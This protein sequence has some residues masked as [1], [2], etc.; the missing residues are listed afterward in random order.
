MIGV[1]VNKGV[2]FSF[3]KQNAVFLGP[4]TFMKVGDGE[5]E[6]RERIRRLE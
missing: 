3:D 4:V 1:L 2:V 6:V 5:K